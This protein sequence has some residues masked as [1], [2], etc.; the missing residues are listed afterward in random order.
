M[1]TIQI[2]VCLLGPLSLVVVPA[3]ADLQFL[4]QTR[5]A[6]AQNSQGA[7]S[8]AS[9][10]SFDPFHGG[11]S[12][13]W[14]YTAGQ[15]PGDEDGLYS[16]EAGQDSTFLPSGIT[17]QGYAH[18]H[19]PFYHYVDYAQSSL[20]DLHVVFRMEAAGEFLLAGRLETWGD[21]G[22][23]DYGIYRAKVELAHE[24]G[25]VYTGSVVAGLTPAYGV[26]LDFYEPLTLEA[27]LYTLD[28]RASAQAT[29]GPYGSWPSGD[30]LI[31]GCGGSG[32]AQYNV[33]LVAIPVPAVLPLALCGL[34][35]VAFLRRRGILP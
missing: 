4:N 29:C 34:G 3:Q 33:Q 12:V 28:I 17:A 21:Y 15:F 30:E 9:A 8:S 35:A 16:A 7:G 26:A 14:E 25:I 20:S 18:D 13:S 27:G 1:K 11:A 10:S 2:A 22:G 6:S 23:T 32:A 31:P 5:S 19:E 24:T